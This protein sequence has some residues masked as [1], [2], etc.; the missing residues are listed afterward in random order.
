VNR[1]A[2]KKAAKAVTKSRKTVTKPAKAKKAVTE[3]PVPET[4]KYRYFKDAMGASWRM[5]ENGVGDLWIGGGWS[6]TLTTI[7]DLFD[8]KG[9]IETDEHGNPLSSVPALSSIAQE[10]E[11]HEA[12]ALSTQVGGDHYKS[13]AIQPAE[14]AQKNGLGYCEGLALKYITRHKAKHGAEDIRKAIHCLELLL[15]IEYPNA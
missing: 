5:S 13:L 8:V 7:T 15:E 3:V 12:T 10:A 6:A 2:A 9:T 1:K 4:P 14:Y 11:K